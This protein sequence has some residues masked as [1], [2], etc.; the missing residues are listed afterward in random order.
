M[1]EPVYADYNATAPLRPE[2]KNA[3]AEWLERVGNPSSVHQFGRQARAAVERARESLAQLIGVKPSMITF[4]SGGTE[5]NALALGTFPKTHRFCSAVEHEAVLSHVPL[6]H[7]LAVTPDGRVNIDAFEKRLP[8]NAFVSV[9]LAN[10]ETGVL[11]PVEETADVVHAQGGLVHT[12]AVQALG[13]MPV[14]FDA[15][16]VDMMSVSAHKLGGPAGV[17]ALVVREGLEISPM[18][19]GGGQERRKRP[20]TENLLGI[21]GFGAAVEASDPSGFEEQLVRFRDHF[22]E[23]VYRH[24]GAVVYSANAPRLPNT[25]CL[26]LND[27][28]SETQ[29]MA[30]DLAGVALSAGSAC[31]SGKV[32]PSHVLTAMGLP[33]TAARS[34]IRVSLGWNTTSDDVERLTTAW[35]DM[36]ERLSA[37]RDA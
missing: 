17:G 34:A 27:V 13:K 5:A 22:E 25:T 1:P 10:N 18:L 4:T 14:N 31:S 23:A 12:D 33:E 21:I 26:G 24:A 30:M 29:V 16:G 32:T 15:L 35:T 28:K 3:I 8:S 2:A 11:Q 6:E 19:S 20:G 9:M 37:R 36:A 7:H